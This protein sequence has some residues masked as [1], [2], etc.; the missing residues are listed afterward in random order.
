MHT[1]INFARILQDK[2]KTNKNASCRKTYYTS[3]G[4]NQWF[5]EYNY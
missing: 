1:N 4:L 5:L 2:T 3:A